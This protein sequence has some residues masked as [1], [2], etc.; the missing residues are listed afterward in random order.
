MGL[1]SF[2]YFHLYRNGSLFRSSVLSIEYLSLLSVFQA[3]CLSRL[4]LTVA[5]S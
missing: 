5:S 1:R 4:F 3:V 2:I